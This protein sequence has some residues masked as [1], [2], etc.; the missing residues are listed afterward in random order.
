MAR[1]REWSIYGVGF[2]D[3][4]TVRNGVG[5]G[6][7]EL[8]N[9]RTAFL[10]RKQS[11]DGR[12]FRRETRGNE[13]NEGRDALCRLSTNEM[14]QGVLAS[15]FFCSKTFVS[16]SI[17]AGTGNSDSVSASRY[18]SRVARRCRLFGLSPSA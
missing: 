12:I 18:L 14:K 16:A 9:V 10:H 1:Q 4:R 8:D 11:R 5:E 15:A 13:S 6:H 7:A 17:E 3:D 2:L